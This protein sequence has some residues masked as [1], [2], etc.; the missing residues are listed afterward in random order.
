[1]KA[2]AIAAAAVIGTLAYTSGVADARSVVTARDAPPSLLNTPVVAGAN[3][4]QQQFDPAVGSVQN[5]QQQPSSAPSLLNNNAPA[6]AAAAAVV[7]STSVPTATSATIAQAAATGAYNIVFK[8]SCAKP[9]QVKYKAASAPQI[10][11]T[12]APGASATWDS[13][14]MPTQALAFTPYYAPED[15][16]SVDCKEWG[17]VLTR[18]RQGYQWMGANAQ[19]AA[20]CNPVLSDDGNPLSNACCSKANP[21]YNAATNDCPGINDMGWGTLVEFSLATPS[22]NLDSMDLSTNFLQ[23][24]NGPVFFNIPVSV[25]ANNNQCNNSK[26]SSV[27]FPLVC[28]DASCNVAYQSP[29]DKEN[30][31]AQIQCPPQTSYVVNFCP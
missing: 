24:D 10:F 1:M 26:T 31:G 4:Q 8:N 3:Y 5:T 22:F 12:I 7:S 6:A 15:S 30:N 14:N 18:P 16:C 21:N 13:P 17:K 19:Y 11:A 28:A 2:S 23:T 20:V 25:S 29:E 27:Q 9:I